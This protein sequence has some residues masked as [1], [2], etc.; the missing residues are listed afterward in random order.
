MEHIIY[1]LIWPELRKESFV[2]I[3]QLEV[4]LYGDLVLRTGICRYKKFSSHYPK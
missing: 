4:S 1:T 2:K 3:P